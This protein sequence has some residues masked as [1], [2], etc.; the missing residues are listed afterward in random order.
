MNLK[1][2]LFQLCLISVPAKDDSDSF[3]STWGVKNDGPPD[4]VSDV[5]ANQETVSSS[6]WGSFTGSFFENA[7]PVTSPTGGNWLN[8]SVL[9]IS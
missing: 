8:I 6:L 4:K 2:D 7:Q 5:S 1:M 3:F 9:N